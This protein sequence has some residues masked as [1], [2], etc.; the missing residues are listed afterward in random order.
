MS[1]DH[2]VMVQT[3]WE[4]IGWDS[5]VAARGRKAAVPGMLARVDCREESSL[6]AFVG[7]GTVKGW[8]V[9]T[10]IPASS[11]FAGRTHLELQ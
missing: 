2:L 4:E 6:V 8:T 7:E 10:H 1:N 11:P 3:G 9:G 5:T